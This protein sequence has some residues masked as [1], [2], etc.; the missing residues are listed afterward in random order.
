MKKMKLPE[1][2]S[3]LVFSKKN[4]ISIRDFNTVGL[5]HLATQCP[6]LMEIETNS[7]SDNS[8]IICARNTPECRFSE[9]LYY[10]D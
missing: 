1:L 3:L 6:K 2:E 5:V 9:V 8:I 10:D 4:A 7:T